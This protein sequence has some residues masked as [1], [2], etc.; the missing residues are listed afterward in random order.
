MAE[1]EKQDTTE[2][3]EEAPAEETQAEEPKAEEAS[4]EDAPADEEAPA[5]EEEPAEEAAVAQSSPE[6]AEATP[7]ETLTPKQRRKRERSRHSG[8]VRPP[9]TS[10]ERADERATRR[11]AKASGRRRA[12]ASV[13]GRR[14]EPGHGTPP[15]ERAPGTRKVRQGVVVSAKPDKTITVRIEI[16]RRHPTYEKVVRRTNTIHAHDESNQAQEGDIVRVVE[17]RPLSRTKRWR[18][19][20]VLERAR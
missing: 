11:A 14:G 10:S 6:V 7:E 8:E 9:R 20:E 17:S 12:R 3:T 1:D 19:V 4:P 16:T 5:A 13:R 18:L 2:E 15:A